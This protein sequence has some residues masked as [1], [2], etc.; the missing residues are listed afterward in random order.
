MT[1]PNQAPCWS[2]QG[3]TDGLVC[4]ACGALQPPQPV[5]LFTRFGFEPTF[6]VDSAALEKRYFELQRRLH[7]DRFANRPQKERDYSLQHA[8][9]LNEAHQVLRSPVR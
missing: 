3:A 9:N 7:P 2:C 8:A 1:A 4:Q 5:D 6:D